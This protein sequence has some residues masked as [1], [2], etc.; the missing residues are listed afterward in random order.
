MAQSKD[1][2][3]VLYE[4]NHIIAVNKPAGILVHGDETGDTT[5][6]DMV[7]RYIKVKYEKPGDV[8]LGV[9]HRLDRPVSGVVVFART[10]KALTRLNEMF[11]LRTVNKSYKAI[12]TARPPDM[13]GTLT[14][15]II[16]DSEKNVAKAH[17]KEKRG[18]KEAELYYKFES[19]ISHY[20][21]L[22][23]KPVTGRPHQIRAQLKALGCPILGD[24]KYGSAKPMKDRSICLFCEKIAFIH[25][26]KKEEVTIKAPMPVN[27]YWNLFRV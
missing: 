27:E 10:S 21:L 1:S 9:V 19:E 20:I 15:H 11:R 16:K 8:F 2:L 12:V 3:L 24:K 13:E 14:H 7:K 26:V 5:L 18:S 22:V 25:P 4:D 6:Q 23:L 17:S